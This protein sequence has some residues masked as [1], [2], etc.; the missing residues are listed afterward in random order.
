MI[1]TPLGITGPGKSRFMRLAVQTLPLESKATPRTLIPPAEMDSAFD[2]SSAGN[3]T[4]VYDKA[5]PTQT[6]VWASMT[7][8]KGE[9][10]PLTCTIR[11]SFTR[12]PGKYSNWSFTASAIQ[13]SPFAATPT[14]CSP[15]FLP[16][17]G[18]SL[19]L[20]MGLPSKSIT[21]IDPLKLVTQ[22]LSSATPVPQPMPSTPIPVKPVIGGERAVPLGANLIV[23]PPM[24]LM[25]PDC[26]PGSQFW[27]LQRL[28]S[29]SNMS[30]PAE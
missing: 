12:P 28:P 26:E 24:P 6:R 14:P 22:T 27:P 3:R 7:M 2:G 13:T 29:A 10:S 5:L 9:T 30:R 18:K 23:P 17:V 21:P 20:P 1:C 16:A 8:L 4:I 15:P 25:T 11:P 19:A